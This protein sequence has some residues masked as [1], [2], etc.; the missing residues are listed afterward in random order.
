M[1][2]PPPKTM[3]YKKWTNNILEYFESREWGKITLKITFLKPLGLVRYRN[4]SKYKEGYRNNN[5]NPCWLIR[6]IIGID[7][8]NKI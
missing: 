4:V 2:E 3:D 8:Q 5:N 6:K 1:Q 7:E